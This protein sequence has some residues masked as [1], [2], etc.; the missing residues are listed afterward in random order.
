MIYPLCFQISFIGFFGRIKSPKKNGLAIGANSG[1]PL[2]SVFLLR[3]TQKSTS[4]ISFVREFL[5]L[6]ILCRCHIAQI[7]ESI[8]SSISI[9]MVNIKFRPFAGYI[10][11]SKPIS[12]ISDFVNGNNSVSIRSNVPNHNAGDNFSA[13]FYLPGKSSSLQVIVQKSFQFGKFDTRFV[14]TCILP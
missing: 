6:H 8:I 13:S 3:D 1:S 14:H 11:P 9:N 7:I 4:L 12:P 10:K 5:V 2:T